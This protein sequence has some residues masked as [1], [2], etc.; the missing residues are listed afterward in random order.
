MVIEHEFAVEDTNSS[1]Q[2]IISD[3]MLESLLTNDDIDVNTLE[4]E[5][6]EFLQK[7]FQETKDTEVMNLI[8]ETYLS[9][10]Q[11][12]KAKKFIE[13]LPEVYLDSLKP[14]LNLRVAFNS[15]SLSSKTTNETLTSLVQNYSSKNQISAED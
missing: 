5:N 6:D 8:V 3:E 12:V 15:F 13:E 7:V 10:Y 9:E 14:S 1:Q 2:D 11:F 4:S